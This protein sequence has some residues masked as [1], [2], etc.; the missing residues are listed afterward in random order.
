MAS[1]RLR[2]FSAL[3]WV[4]C[5]LLSGLFFVL[6]PTGLSAKVDGPA[7]PLTA[8]SG[9]IVTDTLW[10]MAASPYV[11]TGDLSVEA[12]V[13]L[14][15]EAGAEVRIAEDRR[16]TVSGEL[17]ATGTAGRP[18]TFTAESG[19]WH[20]FS[21]APGSVGRLDH[22]WVGHGGVPSSDGMVIVASNEVTIRNSTFRDG[23]Q[24]YNDA[25][26]YVREASPV[27]EDNL[28]ANSSAVGIRFEGYDAV[29]P[30]LLRNNRF[31]DN[32]DAAV[33]VIMREETANII[34]DGNSSSGSPRNGI[35]IGDWG[36]NRSP[37]FGIITGTVTISGQSDFPILIEAPYI[38]TVPESARLILAA[39]TTVKLSGERMDVQGGLVTEGTPNAPV[40]FTSIR[41][42]SYGGD[43][44]GDGSVSQPAAG[45]WRSI[46]FTPS[47]TQ[48]MLTHTWIG[49]GGYATAEGMVIIE[50]SDLIFDHVTL[51]YG[52]AIDESDQDAALRIEQASP[53]I[54]D[55]TFADNTYWAI[56]WNGFD[57]N[58]PVVFENN[59]FADNGSGAV[60][61]MLDREQVDVTLLGNSSSGSSFNGF[62]ITDMGAAPGITGTITIS[63][64]SDFP[65]IVGSAVLGTGI[66]TRS[67][68]VGPQAH[69]T[70]PPGTLI[71]M[72]T[73]VQVH[74]QLTANGEATNPIIFTALHDD[75][76]G[77]DTN[78]NGSESI[79]TDG[80][81]GG[82][83]FHPGSRGSLDQTQIRY[84]G[85]CGEEG[86]L[87]AN[88]VIES[89]DVSVRQ[90][91]ISHA[92][93]TELAQGLGSGIVISAASP[94][95]IGNM[96][97]D[98]GGSGV[99]I[100]GA[101]A[102][103]VVDENYIGSNGTG[104][105]L[106][107]VNSGVTLN[108]NSIINNLGPG[109]LGEG[110][111]VA[112]LRN[113]S[114]EGNEMGATQLSAAH[115]E[116]DAR[117]N[118]WGSASGPHHAT[119]NP[120]GTGNGVSDDVLFEPWWAGP[121]ENNMFLPVVLARWQ[122]PSTGNSLFLPWLEQ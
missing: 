59:H 100:R 57:K 11:I 108:R 70:L 30:L 73:C 1:T 89:D 64:Q 7:A 85:G 92:G 10:T 61:A 66:V 95:L 101:G 104:I 22:V 55:S 3:I 113:N 111:S 120:T 46:L 34:L 25:L 20:S 99:E 69:L 76:V 39:G 110:D 82:I 28:F 40:I 41:D 98:N 68:T 19:N 27:I 15:I 4:T 32:G 48:S 33:L 31:E 115:A 86:D 44:N 38:V 114:I 16:I 77:G 35:R 94:S 116:I 62:M 84:G 109:I 90:S 24:D 91:V 12:G 54:R 79:P 117:S 63:G 9:A 36:F 49:Y 17:V 122:A 5:A 53:T 119:Q 14:T 78:G 107:N 106:I 87:A 58:K 80:A 81:G 52:A 103:P 67:L 74:G 26:L 6:Q 43:T 93:A 71:K 97:Q 45:D 102:E 88:L 118:F 105:R 2:R 75:S 56:Q 23:G 8:V 50:T 51:A 96:I 21:F 42:D 29:K 13:K 112:V 60:W 37:Y 65:F 18:I 47:S 83:R 72:S 121:P